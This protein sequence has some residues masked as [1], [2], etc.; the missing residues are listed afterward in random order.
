MTSHRFLIK[1]WKKRR[2][3]ISNSRTSPN[4]KS[5]S[6]QTKSQQSQG[7]TRRTNGAA[8]ATAPAAATPSGTRPSFIRHDGVEVTKAVECILLALAAVGGLS[9]FERRV[10]LVDQRH[11]WAAVRHGERQVIWLGID[12]AAK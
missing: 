2:P 12:F 10:E 6:R 11:D 4:P 1:R 8:R 5:I 7:T 3:R 9:L